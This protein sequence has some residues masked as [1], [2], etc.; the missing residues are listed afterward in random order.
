MRLREAGRRALLLAVGLLLG[1]VAAEGMTRAYAQVGGEMGHVLA[2]RDPLNITVE[3]YGEYGYK[4]RPG[5]F[6]EYEN[7]TRATW[8][9]MGFRGPLVAEPKPPGSFRVI[10]LGESTTH[11]YQ[12]DDNQT[13]DAHMRALLHERYPG[14]RFEAVNL[15]LDGYD[16]YQ[17]YQRFKVDGL[18]LSPDLV[19]ANTGINDVRNARFPN[20]KIPDVRTVVWADNLEQLREQERQGGPSLR[21]RLAHY[22]Y[23]ARLFGLIRDNFR[24][25]EELASNSAVVPQPDAVEYFETNI[26]RMAELVEASGAGLVLSTPPSS[27]LSKYAAT[28]V[29]G[30]SYWLADAATTQEYR[31]R[32][33]ARLQQLA[34]EYTAR[35]WRVAYLHL[36]LAPELFQ[37]DCHLTGDGNRVVAKAFVEA[38]GPFVTRVYPRVA[39][40]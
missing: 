39:G 8:N 17:I 11:G 12:V 30:Q 36:D 21:F 6:H 4:Q 34:E 22:L 28:D 14:T 38:L 2:R 29:S 37:D 7:G 13:V 20:L 27:L 40:G 35:G 3:P 33:A 25:R 18:A 10:L 16:S 31:D 15:A 5:R 26:R 9:A 23:A 19:I 1:A 32:L 24:R